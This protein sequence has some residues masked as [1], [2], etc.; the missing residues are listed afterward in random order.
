MG[1]I[2]LGKKPNHGRISE[3]RFTSFSETTLVSYLIFVAVG[4]DF[5]KSAMQGKIKI[6]VIIKKEI[7]L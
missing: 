1:Q 6:A 7:W 3:R 5:L 4:F 2:S